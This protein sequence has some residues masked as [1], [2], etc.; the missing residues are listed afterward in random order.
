M[1]S[2]STLPCLK[3]SLLRSSNRPDPSLRHFFVQTESRVTCASAQIEVDQC[4]EQ[5]EMIE[6]KLAEKTAELK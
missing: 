6:R 5:V 2:V 1:V 3:A 4:L